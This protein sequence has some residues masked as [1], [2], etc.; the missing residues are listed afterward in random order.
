LTTEA[1]STKRQYITLKPE[2]LPEAGTIKVII[3]TADQSFGSSSATFNVDEL[4]LIP[5]VF[6]DNLEG[7]NHTFQRTLKPSSK[8]K[9]TKRSF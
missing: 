9:D 3:Y 4:N 1:E 6:D 7:E 8:I 5:L 2:T